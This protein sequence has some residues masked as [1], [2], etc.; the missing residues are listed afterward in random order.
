MPLFSVYLTI[1]Y[2]YTTFKIMYFVY[3]FCLLAQRFHKAQPSFRPIFCYKTI[4]QN[5]LS[6]VFL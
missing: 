5:A 2:S 6:L 4:T 3:G 1:M